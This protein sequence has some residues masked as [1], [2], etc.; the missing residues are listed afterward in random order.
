[1][2]VQAMKHWRH[3]LPR[4]CLFLLLPTANDVKN[5]WILQNFMFVIK[6]KAGKK[7]VVAE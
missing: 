3:Y 5:E 6:H 2:L 7:N 4:S 1:M